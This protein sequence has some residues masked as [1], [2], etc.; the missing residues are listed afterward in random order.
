SVS[1]SGSLLSV[2]EASDLG[3]VTRLY[4]VSLLP[5]RKDEDHDCGFM[6][7]T[8]MINSSKILRICS[9]GMYN[10]AMSDRMATKLSID[11]V[12]RPCQLRSNANIT[13]A[14]AFSLSSWA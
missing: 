7:R 8:S 4:V 10:E 13:L 2:A 1:S 5:A 12:K 9:N 11:K 6:R 14:L 3:L